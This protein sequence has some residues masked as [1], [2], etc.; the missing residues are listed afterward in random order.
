MQSLATQLSGRTL[1][2]F[3]AVSAGVAVLALLLASALPVMQASVFSGPAAQS[4]GSVAESVIARLPAAA[5]VAPAIRQIA[6]GQTTGANGPARDDYNYGLA[7]KPLAA[8]SPTITI[9]LP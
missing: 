2:R 1:P 5:Q 4:V 9:F 7:S 6:A 3:S 8:I